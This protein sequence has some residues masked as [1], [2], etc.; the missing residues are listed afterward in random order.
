ML[1]RMTI[2]QARFLTPTTSAS[3]VAHCKKHKVQ[4][5][6]IQIRAKDREVNAHWIGDPDAET[7]VLYLHGGGYTQPASDGHFENLEG[8]VEDLKMKQ[9]FRSVAFL[10]LA[11]SLAPEATHPTQ[12]TEAAAALSHLLDNTGRVPSNV[13]I[14]GDSAGGNL[15]LAVLSHLLHPHAAVPAVKLEQP[16]GGALLY[17]PWASFSTDYHSYASNATLD[18]LPPL[19][20]RRWS[21]MF[22][23]KS[24][25]AD[26]EADP[27]PVTGDAWTDTS[28]N[29]ASW[30]HGLPRVVSD[31]FV[32]YGSYEVFTDPIMELE[33]AMKKGWAE[34]D[35][36]LS[37]VV[38][39]EGVKEAHIAPIVDLMAP[40]KS[41]KSDTRLAIEGWYKAR[42]QK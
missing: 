28:R 4:P 12:L 34:S 24:N 8:L 5:K 17:S 41:R 22:L 31:V 16:L 37:R 6:T 9:R 33:R 29:P 15:A 13:F 10:F 3:Y 39:L 36:E 11:Y 23:G 21:A 42:L 18:M 1:T 30:W 2:P 40:G 25:P 35:G 27:G 14:S 19:G 32:A 7:V 20:L 38:F 26:A